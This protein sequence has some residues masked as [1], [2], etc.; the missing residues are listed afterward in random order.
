MKLKKYLVVMGMKKKRILCVL[1]MHRTGT[2]CLAR[3]LG[4]LG[5]SLGDKLSDF[6]VNPLEDNPKG[7]CEDSDF[8]DIN[9]ELMSLAGAEWS[10]CKKIELDKISLNAFDCIFDRA[11]DIISD[12]VN[13]F[14]GLVLK[15]PRTVRLMPFWKSVFS[16]VASDVFYIISYRHPASVMMSLKK[17]NKF[18]Q[19]KS[20]YLWLVHE[21]AAIRETEG[22]RRVLVDYDLMIDQPEIEMRR[23]AEVLGVQWY[24]PSRPVLQ[25]MKD[26]LDDNL[27][28]TKYS[29]QDLQ[30][31]EN[32]PKDVVSTALMLEA[33]ARDKI[34]INSYQVSEFFREQSERLD[35]ISFELS[36][37]NFKLYDEVEPHLIRQESM[38]LAHNQLKGAKNYDVCN[39]IEEK[40]IEQQVQ[41]TLGGEKRVEY[42]SDEEMIVDGVSI[43]IDGP[44]CYSKYNDREDLFFMAKSKGFID[45]YLDIF[46]GKRVS[47]IL[48]I[49]IFK[50]GSTVFFH[51]FF[52]PIKLVAID[53]SDQVVSCLERYI[54]EAAQGVIKSYY[55]VSQSSVDDLIAIIE[56]EFPNGIDMVIDDAS[57]FYEESK[58]SFETVF[59]YVVKGGSYIIED[60]PW[61]HSDAF[62]VPGNIWEDKKSLTNLIFEILMLQGSN[63]GIVHKIESVP[64]FVNIVRG[65]YGLNRRT[66]KIDDHIKNRGMNLNLI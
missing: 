3:G 54:N 33:I 16:C 20:Y 52:N 64:G 44:G 41:E 59:P 66:F 23:L 50:G 4:A 63:G 1:G 48:E 18:S 42:I 7:F 2:S 45:S 62:Q 13:N 12:K 60:W 21:V 22:E 31:F 43:F 27:R 51:K 38:E 35:H 40:L 29:S 36:Y 32:F 15:N 47:T 65:G 37:Y 58:V 5:F 19:L 11:V 53:I 10:D 57:H 61:S 46:Y 28:N 14:D 55:N 26:F 24:P 9:V 17:R 30:D 49:G 56:K 39:P 6:Y 8:N 34:Y 25:Y